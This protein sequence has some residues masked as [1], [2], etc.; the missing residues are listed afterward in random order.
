MAGRDLISFQY[1]D[2]AAPGMILAFRN[3][4]GQKEG[5]SKCLDIRMLGY[6]HCFFQGKIFN[7]SSLYT[8]YGVN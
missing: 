6:P 1:L 4:G 3:G 2:P 7:S 8:F 5:E